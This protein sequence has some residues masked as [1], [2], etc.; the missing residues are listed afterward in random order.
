[1]TRPT[2][3]V[4]IEGMGAAARQEA[5]WA[6]RWLRQHFAVALA[7]SW[8]DVERR[9]DPSV[10]IG[11]VVG[12]ELPGPLVPP[13]ALLRPQRRLILVVPP[14]ARD[15][16]ILAGFPA[17]GAGWIELGQSHE[18]LPRLVSAGLVQS[19]FARCR[20]ALGTFESVGHAHLHEMLKVAVAPP[21]VK[22]FH[23]VNQMAAATHRSRRWLN[24]QW[25]RMAESTGVA[26]PELKDLVRGILFL[27]ALGLWLSGAP[28]EVCA[29]VL[30]TRVQDLHEFFQSFLGSGPEDVDLEALPG[31]LIDL[32][33]ELFGWLLMPGGGRRHVAGG[34]KTAE[35]TP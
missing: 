6:L 22:P 8:D 12:S 18:L 35:G 9:M 17:E 31:K 29:S 21:P 28:M 19:L 2:A 10:R 34:G 13:L 24:L 33:E 7:R 26:R 3:I 32:E 25:S 23:S 1:M 5:A 16:M 27:R 20:S 15:E 4:Y 14:E 30:E 11:L